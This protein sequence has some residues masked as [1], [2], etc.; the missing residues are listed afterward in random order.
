LAHGLEHDAVALSVESALEVRIHDVDVFVVNFCVLHHHDDGG[1]GVVD[2]AKE[3][4]S[5]LL[6]DE[7][8]VGPR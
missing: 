8:A 2:F 4:E 7:D 5:I 3:S 1:E 6:L